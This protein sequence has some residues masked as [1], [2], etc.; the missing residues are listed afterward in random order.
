MD[1]SN[2]D[3]TFLAT[4]DCKNK[5]SEDQGDCSVNYMSFKKKSQ[6]K[7]TIPTAAFLKLVWASMKNTGANSPIILQYPLFKI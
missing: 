5:D 3:I 2:L 1:F 4:N 6:G 7:L